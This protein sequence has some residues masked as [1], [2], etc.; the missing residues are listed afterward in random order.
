MSVSSSRCWPPARVFF[1]SAGGSKPE[2]GNGP[3]RARG[4]LR[5]DARLAFGSSGNDFHDSPERRMEEGMS[6]V[7]LATRALPEPSLS[8]LEPDFEVRVLTSRPSE[9][10]LVSEVAAADAL[11]TLV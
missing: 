4:S 11:I 2:R 8:T 9:A 1:S 10:Q 6:P 5:R 7:V 3:A